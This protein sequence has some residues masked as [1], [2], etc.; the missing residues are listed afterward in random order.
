M[1]RTRSLQSLATLAY[2]CRRP[3][4]FRAELHAALMLLQRGDLGAREMTGPWAGELGQ[5]QFLPSDYLRYAVDYDGDGRRNLLHSVP[6]VLA[7]TAS[8]LRAHGWTAGQPWLEEVRVPRQLPWAEAALAIRHPRSQWAGW[9][10]TMADGRPLPADDLPASL[11]LP[12]GRLGP[13][14]LA[15]PNF[16]VYTQWNHSIVYATTAAYFATRLAGAP[17]VRRGQAVV[18]PPLQVRELQ[19]LLEQAGFDVGGADGV[20]GEQTRNAVR[21]VQVQ[22]D[23]PADAYPTSELLAAVRRLKPQPVDRSSVF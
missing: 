11:L 9:G 14:F 22:L 23:F 1:G 10:V 15:Y 4:M 12:L 13:A 8:L 2:D 17:V 7:S 20:L 18:M 21:Q 6:D 5:V 3:A 16:D 19:Q